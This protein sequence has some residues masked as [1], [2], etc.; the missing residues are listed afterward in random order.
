MGDE[1]G[2]ATVGI[3]SYCMLIG[4]G[5]LF[6]GWGLKRARDAD[7]EVDQNSPL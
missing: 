5:L 6:S 4:V 3:V 1:F 2:D 7:Q